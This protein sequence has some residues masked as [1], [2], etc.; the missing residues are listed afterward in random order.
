MSV[1]P[2]G[3]SKREEYYGTIYTYAP[4]FTLL[5][6][7]TVDG[8]GGVIDFDEYELKEKD[9]VTFGELKSVGTRYIW[10][11]DGWLENTIDATEEVAA[12]SDW[13][14]G[15]QIVDTATFYAANPVDKEVTTITIP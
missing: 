14:T 13:W 1:W 3:S 6:L 12:H 10:H 2:N 15:S 9:G 7:E 11:P 8:D 5:S 4:D